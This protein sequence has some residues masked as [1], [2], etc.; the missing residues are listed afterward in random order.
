MYHNTNKALLGHPAPFPEVRQVVN[1]AVSLTIVYTAKL[2]HFTFGKAFDE[3]IN[4]TLS[5][6]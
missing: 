6:I 1:E 5:I 4:I 3:L 2:D